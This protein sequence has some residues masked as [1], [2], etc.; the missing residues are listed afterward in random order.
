[1]SGR[2]GIKV[3]PTDN[4]LTALR[5]FPTGVTTKT[6]ADMLDMNEHSLRTR[7]GKIWMYGGPVD[8]EFGHR[9]DGGHAQSIWRP[10]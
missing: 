2:P 7:L 1:M 8:R 4:V 6:L 3:V 5:R 10:R 9:V